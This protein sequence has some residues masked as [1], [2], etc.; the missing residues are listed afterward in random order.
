MTTVDSVCDLYDRGLIDAGISSSSRNG[1]SPIGS[2]D[3]DS[4]R[5]FSVATMMEEFAERGEPVKIAAPMVRYSKLAFRRLVRKYGVDLCF[6]PMIVADAFINSVK[7]QFSCVD[8]VLGNPLGLY[9]RGRNWSAVLD[10]HTCPRSSIH[11][12]ICKSFVQISARD[13]DFTTDPDND[14]PLIAQFAA[15]NDFEL[16]T[17]AE[18][19]YPFCDGV[20]LN[21]GCPQRWAIQ[22]GFGCCLLRSVTSW[23]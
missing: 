13:S 22:D 11:S 12:S 3:V 21:C 7:G 8:A 1:H 18:I 15:K 9:C 19:V 16:S 17:A 23:C 14:R 2:P 4:R 6:T 5:S 20:D 10:C